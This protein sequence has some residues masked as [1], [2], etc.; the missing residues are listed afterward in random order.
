MRRYVFILLAV[1]LGSPT[2]SWSQSAAPAPDLILD[3]RAE[4]FRGFDWKERNTVV[5]YKI[6]FSPARVQQVGL[7]NV[8]FE[9]ASVSDKYI[10]FNIPGPVHYSINRSSGRF[11]SIS[12]WDNATNT[13]GTCAPAHNLF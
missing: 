4:T 1:L 6:W 11:E 7:E 12:L 10:S 2:A 3:C 5:R 13:T 8:N 9:K